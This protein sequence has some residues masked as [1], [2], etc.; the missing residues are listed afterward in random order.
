MRL[1]ATLLALLAAPVVALPATADG[2]CTDPKICSSFSL[3]GARWPADTQ[4]RVVVD[5]WVNPT[6]WHVSAEEAVGLFQAAAATWEAA[7]PRLDL[8]YRGTVDTPPDLDDGRSVFGFS[9]P[10]LPVVEGAHAS[11]RQ[12]DGVIQEADIVIN[13]TAG[14][15]WQQCEQRDGACGGHA[16]EIQTPVGST[17]TWMGELQGIATHEIGHVLGLDHADDGDVVL[18]M[19][20]INDTAEGMRYQT[21]GRGDVRGIRALYPCRGCPAPKVFAP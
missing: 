8:R 17:H 20:L 1:R 6:T 13:I 21:L 10:L 15:T 19:H 9:A 14:G 12:V 5:Y 2:E 7:H 18:T 11:V 4:G 3:L 16:D